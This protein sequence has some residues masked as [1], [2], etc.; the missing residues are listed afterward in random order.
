VTEPRDRAAIL[1]ETSLILAA[2]FWGLN[3]AA[4]KYAA[5]YIPPLVLVALRFAGSPGAESCSFSY[6][7]SSNPA[8]SSGGR[9]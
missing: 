2:V 1:T 3:F 5:D 7:S 4:T 6:C 8:I 9:I